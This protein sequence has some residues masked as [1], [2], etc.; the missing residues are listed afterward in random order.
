MSNRAGLLQ[1]FA[2]PIGIFIAG[3]V[4][5]GTLAA[6]KGDE[7]AE[8]VKPAKTALSNFFAYANQLEDKTPVAKPVEKAASKPH[9]LKTWDE[10]KLEQK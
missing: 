4:L 10:F 2:S 6:F 1:N 3:T 9:E 7:I 5:A 8:A